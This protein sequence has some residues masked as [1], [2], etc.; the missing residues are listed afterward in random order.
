M[1]SLPVI[2]EGQ[3]LIHELARKKRR[4]TGAGPCHYNLRT[5]RSYRR[6]GFY[7]SQLNDSH[8]KQSGES[9]FYQ[10][11]HRGTGR[12]SLG[13]ST[14]GT[15]VQ[16]DQTLQECKKHWMVHR[17]GNGAGPIGTFTPSYQY[18]LSYCLLQLTGK[19]L[20]NNPGTEIAKF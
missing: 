20:P 15:E 4:C 10:N 8:Q 18:M 12:P 14:S 13:P 5:G 7:F 17:S 1:N 16:S 19:Y 6:S 9:K 11:P 2:M 3:S